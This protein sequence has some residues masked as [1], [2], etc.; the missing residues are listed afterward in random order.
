MASDWIANLITAVMGL[1]GISA[2][3]WVSDRDKR[4]RT[5]DALIDE[6]RRTYVN[7]FACADRFVGVIRHVRS[8]RRRG[9]D[10]GALEDALGRLSDMRQEFNTA[11]YELALSCPQTVI[12]AAEELREGLRERADRAAHGEC[13]DFSVR[14]IRRRLLNVMRVDLGYPALPLDAAPLH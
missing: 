10:D 9:A 12:V 1:A 11:M 4:S 6:R 2:A 14:D 3:V 5:E 13:E 7:L 8:V